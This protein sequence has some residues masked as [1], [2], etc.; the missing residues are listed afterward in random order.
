MYK[1]ERGLVASEIALLVTVGL[2]IV[3]AV[4]ALVRGGSREAGSAAQGALAQ[5]LAAKDTVKVSAVATLPRAV[6]FT[7][8]PLMQPGRIQTPGAIRAPGETAPARQPA[9]PECG[10]AEPPREAGA[11]APDPAVADNAPL[12][13]LHPEEQY[14]PMSA[15]EFINR[16]ELRWAHDSG[17]PDDK[18]ADRCAVS[19]AK[20]GSG[21]YSKN[22]TNLLCM[23]N[24]DSYS[25]TDNTR[26]RG[27]D[28]G[29]E[30]FFLDLDNKHRKG[31]G[32]GA[33]VY[34]D[35]V[36]GKYVTYWFFYGYSQPPGPDDVTSSLSHEGD[37]ESVTIMLDKRGRPT[38]A[39]FYSHGHPCSVPWGQVEKSGGRPVIYSAE[40]SHASYPTAGNHPVDTPIPG[41]QVD[42]HTGKGSGW[43][44]WNNLRN[45]R[46]QP[47]YGYGGAWGEVGNIKDTTG[48]QGPSRYK[49]AVPD[50]V[51][52]ACS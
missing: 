52:P 3:I 44:T 23:G 41:V 21:G 14:Q 2:A 11:S 13:Y 7:P 17:C 30:G 6:A 31:S 16:S 32:T 50:S 35:Y 18:V 22:T 8:R 42:D 9:A 26:P 40:G 10:E 47:W 38:H 33:P 51:P 24:D 48:P 5:G 25:T 37:W 27:G 39:I 19:S 12:V 45:V 34:Y 28:T 20:L 43:S 15:Q 36:P 4:A 1:D 29:G 46:D 49:N